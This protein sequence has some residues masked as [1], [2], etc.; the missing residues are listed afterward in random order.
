[1]QLYH[2]PY[3]LDS[4]KVRLAL[5]EKGIDYTSYHVNPL[6]GKNMDSLFFRMNPSARLPV[7]QNGAHILYRTMDIMQY[8]DRLIVASTEDDATAII[9]RSVMD[10]MEKIDGWNPKIF[11]LSH[12]PDKYRLFISRFI[13][14]VI[15]AR[16][17]EAP[18]LASVYH[19]KLRDAYET[20]DKLKNAEIV[21]QS[22]EKLARL[23]DDAELQLNQTPYL[24]GEDFT[25][26][27]SMFIPVLARITLL[28]LEEEYINC[29]PRI[30]KYYKVVKRRPSYKVAI[31]KYFSGWRKYRTLLK[32][33]C[34]LGVR[35]MIR[36][37][38]QCVGA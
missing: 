2:H 22:E 3:S 28:G 35:N 26:A 25:M 32:T 31:G 27:D 17:A 4:Q 6:T 8:I 29:R 30:A 15:I 9:S 36:K 23:L 14:R 5:E 12:V 10:W 1:M 38:Q 7:F 18:E 37:V 19:V 21:K 24:A 20:E 16:M 34:F 33:L 13:R 11:T